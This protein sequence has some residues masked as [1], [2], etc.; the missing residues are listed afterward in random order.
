M[1]KTRKVMSML[2]AAALVLSLGVFGVNQTAQA[3]TA[4]IDGNDISEQLHLRGR[5]L[6]FMVAR[7]G[8]VNAVGDNMPATLLY[9]GGYP[10]MGNIVFAL[11]TDK[12]YEIEGITS[13]NLIAE[14]LGAIDTA[15]GGLLRTE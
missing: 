9:G 2:L 3:E 4:V 13:R 7:N 5:H 15:V 1:K 10:I 14:I 8:Y 11:E 6:V 12:G